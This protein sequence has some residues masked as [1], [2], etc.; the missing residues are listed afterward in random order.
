MAFTYFFR[1]IQ[2]LEMIRDHVLPTL[3]TRRYIRIW[4][5]GCAMGA[6]PFSLA[7]ILRE[8][9]GPMIFRNVSILATDIDQMNQFGDIIGSGVY[10]ERDVKRIPRDLFNRYF[11][12]NREPGHFKLI[13][14]IKNR[15]TF[16]RHDL[17]SMEAPR[18]DFCVILCKNVLLHLQPQER[19]DVLRMF[20]DSLEDGGYFVTEQTQK[21]PGEVEGFFEQV[22]SHA[23]L[24]KKKQVG[25]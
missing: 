11:E 16:L 3:R 13:D 23:Q 12:S 9:M 4:D 25:P 6:E 18:D 2:T 5:A 19:V 17:L 1:D 15:V 10:P 20:H 22:V 8:N 21:L 7:I 24:F 14:E